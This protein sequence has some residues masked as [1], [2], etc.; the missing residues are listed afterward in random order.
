NDGSREGFHGVS[1]VANPAHVYRRGQ[2]NRPHVRVSRGWKSHEAEASSLQ[3]VLDA[4]RGHEEGRGQQ[5]SE[6]QELNSN[7]AKRNAVGYG[8]MTAG[9]RAQVRSIACPTSTP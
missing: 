3:S 6:Q 9:N 7:C 5:R 4:R 2:G 1:S 8:V